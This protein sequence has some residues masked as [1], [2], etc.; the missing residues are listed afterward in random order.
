MQE[1]KPEIENPETIKIVHDPMFPNISY[2]LIHSR[3]VTPNT[4]EELG[5]AD[6]LC[7]EEASFTNFVPELLPMTLIN[8]AN[9]HTQYTNIF[10]RMAELKRPIC[11]VDMAYPLA[12]ERKFSRRAFMKGMGYFGLGSIL[13]IFDNKFL[14]VPGT[15]T[16]WTVPSLQAITWFRPPTSE[17][18]AQGSAYA[19]LFNSATYFLSKLTGEKQHLLYLRDAVMAWKTRSAAR[20]EFVKDKNTNGAHS[21]VVALPFG[22]MHSGIAKLLEMSDANLLAEVEKR[23]LNYLKDVSEYPEVFVETLF[24]FIVIPRVVQTYENGNLEFHAEFGI[25]NTLKEIISKVA[26]N[27]VS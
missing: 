16:K 7:V 4:L 6:M 1:K 20:E 9:S 11:F 19:N 15:I 10:K 18:Q 2:R 22:N 27:M 26:P 14:S 24:S 25:D 13:E 17:A 8:Y 12:L 23:M 3:H 5:N 21:K